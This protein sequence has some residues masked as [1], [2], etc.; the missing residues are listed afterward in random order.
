M[1]QCEPPNWE[2]KTPQIVLRVV[3]P[4]GEG[5]LARSTLLRDLYELELCTKSE[6]VKTAYLHRKSIP[7]L[8]EFL[9]T[10]EKL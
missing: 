1:S 9:Q 4:C 6:T 8:I 7:K 2:L 3:M 5:V 10:L